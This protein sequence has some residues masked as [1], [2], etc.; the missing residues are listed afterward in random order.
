MT[1]PCRPRED[2]T[3][4]FK[5]TRKERKVEHEKTR[6]SN[7][8]RAAFTQQDM[9]NTATQ[10]TKAQHEEQLNNWK[11]G[12]SKE[13]PLGKRCT[14]ADCLCGRAPVPHNANGDTLFQVMMCGGMVAFMTTINGL[15]NTGLS[16]LESSLW[17]YPLIFCIALL[18]R[19]CLTSKIMEFL[20]HR[21]IK[22]HFTGLPRAIITP[23]ANTCVT[24]PIMCA[25]VTMLLIGPE[26]FWAN[27]LATLP[28]TAPMSILVSYFIVGPAVKMLFN[29]RISP[30]RGMHLLE[31]INEEGAT[32]ARMMGIC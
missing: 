5:I 27:Y 2:G 25:I 14:Y 23:I 19:I 32:I 31:E 26:S 3:Q 9:T 10:S 18:L 11:V 8:V 20:M 22:P 1:Q 24:A 21:F 13:K 12:R 28:I 15:R 29:N 16:F 6:Q 17:L 4:P 7:R 30:A